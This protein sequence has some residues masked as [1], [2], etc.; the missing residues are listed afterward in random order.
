MRQVVPERLRDVQ[1]VDGQRALDGEPLGGREDAHDL[2]MPDR[3]P[4]DGSREGGALGGGPVGGEDGGGGVLVHLDA[5]GSV[6]VVVAGVDG[7]RQR[8]HGG[9]VGGHRAHH[10]SPHMTASG[11]PTN[12]M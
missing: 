3:L 9:G 1:H 2:V 6:A 8:G 4:A 12:A 10:P 5:S 7:S 11:I